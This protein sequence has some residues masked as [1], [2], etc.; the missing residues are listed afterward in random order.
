MRII[1]LLFSIL[2]KISGLKSLGSFMESRWDRERI[3]M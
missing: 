3:R 1:D 2:S